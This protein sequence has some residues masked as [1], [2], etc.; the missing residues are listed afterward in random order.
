[1]GGFNACVC[2]TV[3]CV[4]IEEGSISTH[5]IHVCEGSALSLYVMCVGREYINDLTYVCVVVELLLCVV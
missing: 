3:E 1:M 2:D 5:A 4:H